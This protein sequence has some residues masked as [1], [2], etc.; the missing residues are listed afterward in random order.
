MKIKLSNEVYLGMM[1]LANMPFKTEVLAL[2]EIEKTDKGYKIEGMYIPYQ[3]SNA[4]SCIPTVEGLEEVLMSVDDISKIH[5]WFHTHPPSY[6]LQ[7]SGT[8][9]RTI[10]NLFRSWNEVISILG[11]A[12]RLRGRVNIPFYSSIEAELIIPA[13][14]HVNNYLLNSIL[15]EV[16]EKVSDRVVM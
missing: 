3:H 12:G 9:E 10:S 1:A 5:G 8:D 11:C 7:W 6:G 15:K 16:Q 13:L 4:G 2:L 14:S